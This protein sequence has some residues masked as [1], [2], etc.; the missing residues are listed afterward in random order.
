MLLAIT[1]GEAEMA[2]TRWGLAAGAIALLL[3][4]AV[5]KSEELGSGRVE[6][7]L[8][9]DDVRGLPAPEPQPFKIVPRLRTPPADPNPFEHLYTWPARPAVPPGGGTRGTVDPPDLNIE[10]IPFQN[11]AP[12]DTVGDVGADHYIQMTNASV[13]QIFGKDGTLL[14]GPFELD[15]LW[16]QGGACASSGGDPIV[17]YDHLAGRWLMSEFP[18]L[19]ESFL[20]VY[21]S[22]T[23]DPIAGGWYT[24][25]FA[26]PNFPDYPKYAVWP[27]GYY[28]STNERDGPA[29]YALDRSSML[30]GLAA[31]APQRFT[32]P[33]LAGFAFQALTPGDLDGPPPPAGSPNYFMRQRDDEV[34]NAG[35]NDPAH[36][37]LEIWEFQ[38]DFS[39]PSAASFRKIQDLPVA[40]FDS[41]LCGLFSFFC[42]PQ[43]GT[44]ITLDPLR[45]V[46]M[47]R[48]Q[49]RHFGA[50]KR[51]KKGRQ[52]D[53]KAV[54]AAREVLVG[55]FVTDVTGNDRG[56]IRWFEL[57]RSASGG[58]EWRLFQ[59]GTFSPDGDNRWMGSIAM[60]KA[61]NVA[62]GYS[63]SSETTYPSIRYTGRLAKDPPGFMRLDEVSIVEGT[64]SQTG[65]TRW[66]DYSSMNVDPE[67]DCTFWYTNE[68]VGAGG[69]WATRIARFRLSAEEGGCASIDRPSRG[70]R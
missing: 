18:A 19:R 50:E 55:N 69:G 6:P 42:F 51:G 39:D 8:F 5:T 22:M 35:S 44:S 11:L 24:Y 34:H 63:V 33:A 59:E 38:A 10:G 53:G 64:V 37:F 60:D 14:A 62:L 23:D 32:A 17:L 65:N 70:R 26:T 2:R 58:D 29:A 27:D 4:P 13:V 16:T 57:R 48:L 20:C 36:D 61:G 7:G 30:A 54:E 43:P 12:P 46:I 41:D 31:A 49:Y 25:Q 40:E 1:L 68:Y 56:G 3:A 28:V 67:D 47:W 21:I 45:E 66:G 9:Y 52:D 15:D